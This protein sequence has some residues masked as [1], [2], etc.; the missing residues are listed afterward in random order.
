MTDATLNCPAVV[1]RCQVSEELT[2]VVDDI[3]TCLKR[4]V[5]AV[6][7]VGG[8]L[9]SPIPM[10]ALVASQARRG[11]SVGSGSTEGR[12]GVT[13]AMLRNGNGCP[14]NVSLY[15][16]VFV[17]VG[18]PVMCRCRVAVIP[19]LLVS[20]LLVGRAHYDQSPT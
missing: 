8:S 2:D 14:A 4:E 1:A 7:E 17:P 16:C 5:A 9:G 6:S 12:G 15:R 3:V 19:V 13:N 18:L 11:T 20:R 10:S